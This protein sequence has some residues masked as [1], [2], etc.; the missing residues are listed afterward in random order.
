[1]FIKSTSRKS[2]GFPRPAKKAGITD[3]ILANQSTHRISDSRE[4]VVKTE[5]PLHPKTLGNILLSSEDGF[6]HLPVLGC[7]K[8]TAPLQTA[9]AFPAAEHTFFLLI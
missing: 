7:I 6:K 3:C 2:K 1:M 4:H 8:A 5:L 9:S